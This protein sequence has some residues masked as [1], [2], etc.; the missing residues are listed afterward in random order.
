[1]QWQNGERVIVWPLEAATGKL[2]YPKPKF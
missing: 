2:I 1:M